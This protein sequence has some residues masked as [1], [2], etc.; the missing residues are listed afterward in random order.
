MSSERAVAPLRPGWLWPRMLSLSLLLCTRRQAL[1]FLC[2]RTTDAANLTDRPCASTGPCPAQPCADDFIAHGS[3]QIRL[4]SAGDREQLL[5]Q[6]EAGWSPC[7]AKGG[8]STSSGY[9]L[10]LLVVI[11]LV[12]KRAFP[13]HTTSLAQAPTTLG[14]LR[15]RRRTSTQPL[16]CKARAC[17]RP[18]SSQIM[19]SAAG[20]PDSFES[21]RLGRTA[22]LSAPTVCMQSDIAVWTGRRLGAETYVVFRVSE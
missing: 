21:P 2:C 9:S 5:D 16:C 8:T 20:P 15:T 17:R 4:C 12:R 13:S 1:L 11:E 7:A 19:L 6:V 10:V 14:S 3:K 22:C 18:N